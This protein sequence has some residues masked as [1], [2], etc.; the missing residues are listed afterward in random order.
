MGLVVGLLFLVAGLVL[1]SGVGDWSTPFVPEATLG[2]LLMVC[3]L[4]AILA[5]IFVSDRQPPS[6]APK[7]PND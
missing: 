6:P 5:G 4:A 3:G 7:R 1:V 2:W